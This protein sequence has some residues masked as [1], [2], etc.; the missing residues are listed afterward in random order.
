MGGGER[1]VSAD[2]GDESGDGNECVEVPVA[3]AAAGWVR[4]LAV[5]AGEDGADHKSKRWECRETVVLLSIGDGEEAED[6]ERPE[7]KGAGRFEF[8]CCGEDLIAESAD[9]AGCV[10]GQEDGPGHD[11]EGEVEPEEPDGS[12]AVVVGDAFGEEAGDVLVVEIEPGPASG[13]G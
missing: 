12:E 11:P 2:D 8:A 3:G 9:L 5:G 1:V 6:E 13:G 10:G 7:K 4:L